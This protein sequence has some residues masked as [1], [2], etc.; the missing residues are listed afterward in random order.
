[1]IFIKKI[2]L[3]D[4][5]KDKTESKEWAIWKEE[6]FCTSLLMEGAYKQESVILLVYILHCRF[7]ERV[8]PPERNILKS[9]GIHQVLKHSSSRFHKN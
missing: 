1:M 3:P 9:L 6:F 7:Q 5:Q 8:G 2:K 4:M